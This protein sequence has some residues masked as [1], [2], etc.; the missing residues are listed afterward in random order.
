MTI[1]VLTSEKKNYQFLTGGPWNGAEAISESTI[2][3]LCD[4]A[5]Q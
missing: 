4:I 1:F 5:S 2:T 3:A